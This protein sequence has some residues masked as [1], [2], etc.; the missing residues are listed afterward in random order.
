[1]ATAAEPGA[2][3]WRNDDVSTIVRLPGGPATA[4]SWASIWTRGQASEFTAR[5]WTAA[6]IVPLDCGAKKASP[7]EVLPE[8]TPRKLRPV[9]L[10]EA[11]L[12]FVE[13]VVIQH[14][15]E[16]ILRHVEPHNLGLGTP[17][18]AALIVR[19][20]RGWANDIQQQL[21]EQQQ[22]AQPTQSGDGAPTPETPV[23]QGHSTATARTLVSLPKMGGSGE[24]VPLGWPGPD[25]PISA[26]EMEI[27]RVV[28]P[29][30]VI[31]PIDLENAYGRAHRSQCLAAANAHCSP[32]AALGA[33]QW[34]EQGNRVWQ[35][36]PL[37]WT[38]GEAKR[39]GRQ[40]SRLMQVMFVLGFEFCLSEQ[41]ADMG[42]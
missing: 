42:A 23:A 19:A 30:Q 6:I 14:N 33:A 7:G 4:R 5:L 3:S 10:A 11:L 21:E 29:E 34:T 25:P 1:M 18:A 41:D 28:A 12:K 37:G 26:P 38:A 20:V 9:A 2:S 27:E 31:L 22:Q 17:D 13:G 16:S 40:G 36:G 32:I 24:S 39:G 15:I 35:R 8:P